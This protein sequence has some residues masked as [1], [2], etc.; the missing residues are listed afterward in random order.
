MVDRIFSQLINIMHNNQ[1]EIEIGVVTIGY[2][3]NGKPEF[4]KFKPTIQVTA[5]TQLLDQL[6]SIKDNRDADRIKSQ[7]DLMLGAWWN[8]L[9]NMELAD[10]HEYE[11][12]SEVVLC[13]R[14]SSRQSVKKCVLRYVFKK[15]ENKKEV[16][17]D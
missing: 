17:N 2:D 8:Q 13:E 15:R 11:F 6:T 4:A 16:V 10:L 9:S 14:Y 1:E 5:D 7:A 12:A 3:A